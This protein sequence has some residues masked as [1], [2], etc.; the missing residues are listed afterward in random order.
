M[1]IFGTVWFSSNHSRT[2]QHQL[3]IIYNADGKIVKAAGEQERK[4]A[5]LLVLSASLFS[6]LEG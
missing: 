2:F 4:V 1:G 5:N 6:Q 3:N